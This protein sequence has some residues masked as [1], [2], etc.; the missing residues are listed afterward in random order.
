MNRFQPL[1]YVEHILEAVKLARGYVAGM[2][3]EDFVSDKRT[4]QAVILNIINMGE[5]A[6]KLIREYPEFISQHP[7]VP[8]E[9]VK[10]MR[11]RL[12]HGYFDIQLDI[13]WN[14]VNLH[15]SPLITQLESILSLE[16]D[17]EAIGH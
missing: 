2:T 14:A 13:V 6:T 1:D 11:N 16:E 12:T 4:Q 5:A 10:G 9:V 15:M 17:A 3:N 8:W 7:E